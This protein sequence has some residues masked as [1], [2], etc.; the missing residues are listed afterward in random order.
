MGTDVYGCYIAVPGLRR[1]LPDSDN[2]VY[3]LDDLDAMGE[4]LLRNGMHE[5]PSPNCT[6]ER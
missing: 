1:P 2:L 4:N 3:V 5:T 6:W